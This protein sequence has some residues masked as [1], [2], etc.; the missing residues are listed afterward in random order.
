MSYQEAIKDGANRRE[1]AARIRKMI[2]EGISAKGSLKARWDRNEE[3][4]R[5][6]PD[7]QAQPL[8]EGHEPQT[9]NIIK[10]R[11]NALVTKVCNPLTSQK[12]Y[13]T[14]LGYAADQERLKPA[15]DVIQMLFESAGW[16]KKLRQATTLSCMAAPAFF[17]A[18]FKVEKASQQL[19]QIE[20]QEDLGADYDYV[21]PDICVIHPNDIV[22]YPV[23]TGGIER[24][25]LVADRYT[26]REQEVKEN[27]KSGLWW[28]DQPVTGGD[29]P[30]SWESGRS[31]SWSLT[32][33]DVTSEKKDEAVEIWDGIV[34]LDLDG[35]GFEEKYHFELAYSQQVLLA[36]VPY[37]VT[38]DDGAFVEFSRPWYFTHAVTQPAYREVYHANPIVQDLQP[39]QGTYNDL[40]TLLVEGG[41]MQAFPTAFAVGGSLGD[42]S[43]KRYGPMEIRYLPSSVNM[44]FVS[45]QFDPGVMPT[46]LTQVKN[47]A[48]AIVRVSQAGLAQQ[49]QTG[50]TATAASGYLRGQEEGADEYRDNAA[51][52]GEEMADW[53]RECAYLYYGD[54]QGAY[55][56]S[57]PCKDREHLKKMLRWE[58]TGK[59]SDS[60]PAAI[61]QNVQ[62]LL[63]VSQDPALQGA[64]DKVAL[65]KGWFRTKKL[66]V[67]ESEV[68]PEQPAM[69][70][71]PNGINPQ[72]MAGMVGAP[73][74]GAASPDIE[75]LSQALMQGVAGNGPADYGNADLPFAGPNTAY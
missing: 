28:D 65:V 12:P 63:A 67:P 37:G 39:H 75:A 6:E 40:M 29:N 46:M 15:Q 57:L 66:P 50:T 10:P 70:M 8:Y 33:E 52:S 59:T 22:I 16:A 54:L 31:S 27:Q 45:T 62:E 17:K 71:D 74:D 48:D 14:A 60:N 4:Y 38:T 19:S 64:I 51:M 23:N 25:V 68:F 3:L 2:E 13:F 56:D 72:D 61:G 20:G 53:F 55:G 49:F 41:K 36:L 21:G 11:V 24:A 18:P 7:S 73:V 69:G 26:L 30:Q 42:A 32:S 47:D 58:A 1:L 44:Q 9:W 34:R 35:D 5:G 43:V